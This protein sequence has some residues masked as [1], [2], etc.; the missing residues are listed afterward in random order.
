MMDHRLIDAMMDRAERATGAY[1]TTTVAAAAP[2]D[3][4]RA[5]LAQP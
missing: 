2:D 3:G 1:E 4:P 5:A